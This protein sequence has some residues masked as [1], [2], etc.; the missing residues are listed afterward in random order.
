[1][2][3]LR[4]QRPAQQSN[5]LTTFDQAGSRYDPFVLKASTSRTF[6]GLFRSTKN[7][8]HLRRQVQLCVQ[9]AATVRRWV[10]YKYKKGDRDELSNLCWRR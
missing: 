8:L 7:E 2:L 1:M 6:A 10:G 9:G 3:T 4:I 5:P